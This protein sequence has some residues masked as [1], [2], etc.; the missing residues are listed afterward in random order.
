MDPSDTNELNEQAGSTEPAT[1]QEEELNHSDKMIG[2]FSEPVKTFEQT[3]KFPTRNKD[4]VIPILILLILIGV[5][6]TISMM[7]EEVFLEAKQ[8]QIENIEKLVADGTLTE[9]QGNEAIDRIDE[10]MQYMRG[11]VGWVINIVSVLI[12]GFIF[13]FIIAGIYFLFIKFL[14]RGDGTYA[15]TL[16]ASGLTGYITIIQVIV[17]AI[18]TMAFSKVVEDT[19]LAALLSSDKS[20]IAGWLFAK[21]AGVVSRTH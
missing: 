19:S 2:V 9:E 15:S 14:L 12:F 11:P 5:T 21:T 4:W 8:K 7:D 20:T 16:V 3:A 1:N 13:F 18:L 10:Q 6:K 17:A